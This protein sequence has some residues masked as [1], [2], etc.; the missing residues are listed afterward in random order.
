MHFKS[1]LCFYRLF[2]N[3]ADEKL[4]RDR[5][6]HRS[7]ALLSYEKSNLEQEMN[8]SHLSAGTTSFK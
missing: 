1:D 8:V 2:Q 5:T 6:G 3:Q 4:I 7:N